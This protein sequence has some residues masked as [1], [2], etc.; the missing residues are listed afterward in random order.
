[1][2][3]AVATYELVF[4]SCSHRAYTGAA[5]NDEPLLHKFMLMLQLTLFVLLLLPLP[6]LLLLVLPLQLP[7]PLMHALV[8]YYDMS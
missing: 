1:M 7:L 8:L 4:G 2:A 5:T 3:V 6:L